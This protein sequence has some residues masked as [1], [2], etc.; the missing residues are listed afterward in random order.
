MR[1]FRLEQKK[2]E[3][4]ALEGIGAKI[5]GGR[6]NSVGRQVVYAS[7]SI[8]LAALEILAKT[9]DESFLI[10]LVVIPLMIPDELIHQIR[11]RDLPND[12][13]RKTA[14]T[15]ALGDK[16]IEAAK[17]LA[18]SVP[19]SLVPR[20]Q[21]ILLNPRHPEMRRVQELDHFPFHF[22]QRLRKR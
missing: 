3:K 6:W 13:T 17:W 5:F 7:S 2:Y 15:R 1:A 12:W 21:N 14:D 16:W 10:P 8:A 20:E 22:D 18:L 19:S 11:E 4:E 9:Q